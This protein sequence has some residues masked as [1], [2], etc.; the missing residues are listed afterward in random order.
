MTT[1]D[2]LYPIIH[3]ANEKEQTEKSLEHWR[4]WVQDSGRIERQAPSWL[5]SA[6]CYILKTT[7]EF[8]HA[9]ADL[10]V[11]EK[12]LVPET[13]GTLEIVIRL[14]LCCD[15]LGGHAEKVLRELGGGPNVSAGPGPEQRFRTWTHNWFDSYVKER[16]ARLF[17]EDFFRE[18]G[19]EL[20]AKNLREAAAAAMGITVAAT[21]SLGDPGVFA[22]I[23]TAGAFNSRL[24]DY[25]TNISFELRLHLDTNPNVPYRAAQ[26]AKATGTLQKRVLAAAKD[27]VEKEAGLDEI[28]DNLPEVQRRLLA[29]LTENLSDT[30]RLPKDAYLVPSRTD[31]DKLNLPL[32]LECKGEVKHCCFKG[33]E[34]IFSVSF[35]LTLQR[36]SRA[37]FYKT[38]LDSATTLQ[39]NAADAVARLLLDR[40]S[41]CDAGRFF[42]SKREFEKEIL[43]SI[44]G[45]SIANIPGYAAVN[46]S[47]TT[48][49]DQHLR[50][51]ELTAGPKWYATE[52]ENNSARIS[53]RI[54]VRYSE[55]ARALWSE[56]KGEPSQ[57][58]REAVDS[59]ITKTLA[60]ISP[61]HIY[62]YWEKPRRAGEDTVRRKIQ[63]AIEEAAT[64]A[65]LGRLLETEVALHDDAFVQELRKLMNEIFTFRKMDVL[66]HGVPFQLSFSFQARIIDVAEGGWDTLRE[67]LPSPEKI[68]DQIGKWFGLVTSRLVRT[69]AGQHLEDND[70]L[71]SRE[72]SDSIEPILNLVVRIEGVQRHP[73]AAEV[74][75]FKTKMDGLLEDIGARARAIQDC[76]GVLE[77]TGKQMLDHLSVGE[78]LTSDAHYRQLE[79]M[80]K[81]IRKRKDGL[82]EENSASQKQLTEIKTH[83]HWLESGKGDQS[84]DA[85]V[86]D[87]VFEGHVNEG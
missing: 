76:R 39:K 75:Y 49:L 61:A 36:K 69:E 74:A 57:Q 44:T 28:F 62:L 53:F 14:V 81:E 48:N 33:S 26:V 30:G 41:D 25:A 22:A 21:L 10:V 77:R 54:K 7:K 6:T 66:P 29:F 73:T 20:I 59:A 13:D 34:T 47:L 70:D 8:E 9:R 78:G 38:A 4:Y 37:Q 42:R 24:R 15:G 16:G 63:A 32:T 35:E 87:E 60:R 55:E 52:S 84:R 27:W 71:L 2:Q 1:H 3:Q 51:E 23:P 46:L 72:V 79:D 86:A 45:N 17:L 50:E 31:L 40:F 43:A 18:K 68:R 11:N 64:T 58:L 65:G 19:K 83:I 56:G 67:E 82:E 80:S 5:R 12:V 85:D